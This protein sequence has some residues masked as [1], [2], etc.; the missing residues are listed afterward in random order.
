[1]V[2][3]VRAIAA[4]PMSKSKMKKFANG[5]QETKTVGR[6]LYKLSNLLQIAFGE[7]GSHVIK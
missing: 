1:M 7:A 4:D 6:A 3:R 5:S 2:E